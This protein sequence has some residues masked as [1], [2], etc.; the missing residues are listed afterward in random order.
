M[1]HGTQA[2][3]GHITIFLFLPDFYVFWNGASTSTRG[4]VWLLPV[5][6]PL[7][8]SDNANSLSPTHLLSDLPPGKGTAGLINPRTCLD[9]VKK[10]IISWPYQESNTDSSVV[11]PRACRSTASVIPVPKAVKCMLHDLTI[12]LFSFLRMLSS[13]M[14]RRV[15]L[16]WTDV[17]EE[18]VA[19]ILRVPAG[20]LLAD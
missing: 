17:S 4:G 6:P 16:L 9:A 8:W 1:Y 13:G 14:W 3:S 5:T 20:F 15:V 12:N 11:Q 18:R 2:P 10:R 19:S 7:Q